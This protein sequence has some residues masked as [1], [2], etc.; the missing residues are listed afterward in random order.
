LI[1]LV[2]VIA[3]V[4]AFMKQFVGLTTFGVYT[5]TI[6]TLAF[7]ILGFKFGLLTFLIVI[8]IGSLARLIIARFKLLH[9]PKMALVL[10]FVALSIFALIITSVSFEIFEVKFV[11]LAIFP[12][13]IMSTLA[14]KF[15]GAQ[16]KKG[17]LSALML[18]GESLLVSLVAFFIIGGKIDLVF[19]EIQWEF[20]PQLMLGYP[21]IVIVFIIINIILGRW[22]GLRVFEYIRFREVI[23]HAEE[24]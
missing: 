3:T 19:T 1:L 2:P 4:I 11:S 22:T 14:E 23:K 10:T 8:S 5:P 20:V 9:I 16:S 7:W 6:I 12:M 15:V 24:E 17:F 18:M 13:L 21:E